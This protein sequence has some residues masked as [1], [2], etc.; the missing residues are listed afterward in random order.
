M[1]V[2]QY[3][4]LCLIGVAALDGVLAAHGSGYYCDDVSLMSALAIGPAVVMTDKVVGGGE[5]NCAF[6]GSTDCEDMPGFEC[7]STYESCDEPTG[8]ESCDHTLEDDSGERCTFHQCVNVTKQKEVD[9]DEKQN[10]AGE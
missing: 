3:L 2:L 7:T 4:A 5:C 9:C 10:C 1:K 6:I 8:T